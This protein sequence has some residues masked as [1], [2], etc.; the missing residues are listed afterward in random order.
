M[1]EILTMEEMETRFWSEWVLIN[2]PRTDDHLKVLGGE[3]LFH[4][5]NRDEVVQKALELPPPR[6][7]A[8][9]YFGPRPKIVLSYI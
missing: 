5:P 8:I 2:H 9:R 7:V 4:N 6:N 3:V 1:S